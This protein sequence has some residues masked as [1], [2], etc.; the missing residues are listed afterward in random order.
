MLQC[1]SQLCR[2]VSR[3]VGWLAAGFFL[4]VGRSKQVYKVIHDGKK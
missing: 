3:L 2:L 4:C 1:V